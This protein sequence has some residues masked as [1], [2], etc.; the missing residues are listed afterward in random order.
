MTTVRKALNRLHR[1][2]AAAGIDDAALDA[3]WLVADAVAMSSA[4]LL[5][6]SEQPLTA[7]QIAQLDAY[8]LRRLACEPVSRI[9]G[10]RHFF[11]R[12]FRITSATLDP[13]PESETLVEAVLQLVRE[14]GWTEAPLAIVDVGTGSGCL[15]LA[16]LAELPNAT[17]LGTDISG[18]ALAAAQDNARRLGLATRAQWLEADLVDSLQGPFHIL[19]AN[20]PYIR[21]GEIRSLAPEVRDYDPAGA[22]DGG[23]DG[24][25]FYRRLA[26]EI[27]RL[28]PDGWAVF[29]VGHDQAGA[30]RDLLCDKQIGQAA[31]AVRMFRDLEG[32]QRCVAAKTQTQRPA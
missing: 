30:V 23:M 6:R 14:E 26:P 2:F 31:I 7:E 27:Q 28:I 11:G 21:S 16:L 17:G 10:K 3:R 22:L 12:S 9:I 13:R 18:A 19:V 5:V 29:E 20:P 8:R 24:L 25:S 32:R 4:E 15:L 1:E